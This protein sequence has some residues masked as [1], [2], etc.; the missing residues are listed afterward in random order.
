MNMEVNSPVKNPELD[1]YLE[2]RRQ[3]KPGSPEFMECM[4]VVARSIAMEGKFLAVIKASP[5]AVDM[6]PNGTGTFKEGK[7]FAFVQLTA[8]DGKQ[9]FPAFT[10]WLEVR[11]GEMFLSEDVMALTLEFDDYMKIIG[12]GD[13]I[14]VNPFSDNV[15]LPN[16][17]LKHMAMLK[18]RELKA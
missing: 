11:K 8:P 12:D 1:R 17:G 5:D 9:F 6:R 7:E 13:G 2:E 16:E 14:V 3:L 15:I 10:N 4:N 18:A